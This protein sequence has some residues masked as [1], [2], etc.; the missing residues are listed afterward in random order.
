MRTTCDECSAHAGGAP[1]DTVEK[2][3]QRVRATQTI[4]PAVRR[5][6]LHRDHHRCVVPGCRQSRFVD[7][8]HLQPRCEGG[9]HEEH[10]LI[11]LCSAHHRALHRGELSITGEIGSLSFRH[12]DGTPYGKPGAPRPLD[13][14]AKAFA[15]LRTMGFRE[16]QVRRALDTVRLKS[17]G[18]H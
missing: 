15:A 17:E 3:P 1:V 5:A 10:N 16:N 2:K 11:T 18:S 9:E 4:P 8:H 12:A 7:V 6:V 14:Y 13:A